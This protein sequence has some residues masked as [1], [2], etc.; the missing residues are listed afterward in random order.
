[1]SAT[2]KREHWHHEQRRY[3]RDRVHAQ[4]L[5]RKREAWWI[6]PE[7]LN[8]GMGFINVS[9]GLATLLESCPTDSRS[10]P[11]YLSVRSV[12]T[13]VPVRRRYGQPAPVTRYLRSG[14]PHSLRV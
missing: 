6:D 4:T 13:K 5:S 11:A 8:V 3:R 2:K 10:S 12:G 7:K 1:M 14:F 9:L